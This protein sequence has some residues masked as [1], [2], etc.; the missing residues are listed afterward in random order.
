M[1]ATPEPPVSVGVS[2]MVAAP[3]YE[4]WTS[5]PVLGAVLSGAPA[6]VKSTVVCGVSSFP[7]ASTDQNSTVCATTEP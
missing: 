5:D 2:W 6:T 3:M 4:T 1:V 7:L